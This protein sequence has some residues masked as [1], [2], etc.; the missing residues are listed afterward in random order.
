MLRR[1]RG[2]ERET[3]ARSFGP[4]AVEGFTAVGRLAAVRDVLIKDTSFE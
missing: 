4:I 2:D 3:P 1:T